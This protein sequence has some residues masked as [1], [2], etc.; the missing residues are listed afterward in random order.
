MTSCRAHELCLICV[1]D[2]ASWD[3][4]GQTGVQSSIA[5]ALQLQLDTEREVEAL[6]RHLALHPSFNLIDAFNALDPDRCVCV[7]VFMYSFL[8]RLRGCHWTALCSRSSD[9][10]LFSFSVGWITAESLGRA[11]AASGYHLAENELRSCMDLFDTDRDGRINYSEVS[12]HADLFACVIGTQ[13]SWKVLS[14]ML[15]F[16]SFSGCYHE[17]TVIARSSQTRVTGL[18][19]CRVMC[20]R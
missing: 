19:P 15:A 4:S 18:V 6:R 16:S 8:P 2:V 3:A 1:Q 5:A 11:L 7:D 20:A 17:I 12:C 9:L 10:F 14:I 13:S